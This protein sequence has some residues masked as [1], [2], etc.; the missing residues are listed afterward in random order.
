MAK[1]RRAA[2]AFIV[3]E[4]LDGKEVQ[5][6]DVGRWTGHALQ[7]LQQGDG[8]SAPGADKDV[9]AIENSSDSLFGRGDLIGKRF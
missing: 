9:V 7:C 6:F 1:A 2:S 3:V 4:G 5:Q 8:C